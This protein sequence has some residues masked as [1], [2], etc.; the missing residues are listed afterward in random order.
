MKA[1]RLHARALLA[2]GAISVAVGAGIAC[3]TPQ[4][5]LTVRIPSAQLAETKWVEI[6][7]IPGGCLSP[8][9]LAGGVPAAGTTVRLGYA[10]DATPPAIGDL[11]AGEY[12]FAAVARRSDCGVV[13]TGCTLLDVTRKREVV[14]D[15]SATKDP[16]ASKCV[17]GEV[18]KGGRCLPPQDNTDPAIGEGCTMQ[19]MGAGPL[20]NA[21]SGAP[22]LTAPAIAATTTG[23]LIAY[24][25]FPA[26]DGSASC[27]TGTPCLRADLLPVDAG[28]GALPPI[29][30]TLDG[31]C[32]SPD[33]PDPAGLTMTS[34]GGLLVFSRPP[35]NGKSGLEQLSLDP[36][37]A[38]K[39]RSQFLNTNAPTI[40]LSAHA[41]TPASTAGQSLIAL[42][43]NGLSALFV[44]NG[45]AVTNLVTGFGAPTDT[46]LSL[47]R[48]TTALGIRVQGPG[49]GGDAGPSTNAAK[50]YVVPAS[51]DPKS[52]G[53][54]VAQIDSSRSAIAAAGGRVF[55]VADASPTP[56][57]LAFSAFDL[58]KPTPAAEGTV[59]LASEDPVLALDAAAT[60]ERLFVAIEQAGNL[61]VAVVDG[62]SGTTPS[63][64]RRVD[65][66][67]DARIPAT[68]RDGAIAITATDTRVAVTW[69]SRKTPL[70]ANDTT[71]GYAIFACK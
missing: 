71:G 66:A 60:K 6:A 29:Q 63:F 46:A 51:P 58:G 13:A 19:L 37:G 61:S 25:E 55:L 11:A 52:Q 65:F 22:Y 17:S 35:C 34:A 23:F 41:V 69:V 36:S 68:Y 53:S 47:A 18:C 3:G 28:G 57:E 15:L 38:V 8:S 7:A 14:I 62:A 30:K 31:Y 56:Q 4:V 27:Q 21:I 26:V 12:G 43:S 33:P 44:S 49:G 42:R 20:P 64:V 48:G 10:I 24:G 50:L 39:A 2:T 16:D 67:S 45:S 9:A 32:D 40:A 1:G 54:L 70:G 59:N 5:T